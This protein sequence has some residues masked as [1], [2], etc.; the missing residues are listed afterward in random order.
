MAPSLSLLTWEPSEDLHVGWNT[1]WGQPFTG[2][3]ENIY[4]NLAPLNSLLEF[5]LVMMALIW[6]WWKGRLFRE[7]SPGSRAIHRDSKENNPCQT[8]WSWKKSTLNIHWKDWCWSWSSNTLATCCE[9]LTLWK[10]SWCWERLRAG[11][12]GMTENEIVGWYHWLSGH[13]FE[14]TLGDSE[15]QGRL[16]C[17]GPWGCKESD[18]T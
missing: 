12:E 15:E 5:F 1:A 17:S 2:L 7:T 3:E 8:S 4:R 13:E 11:R 18:T 6:W 10:R 9:E 16:P 14:Q